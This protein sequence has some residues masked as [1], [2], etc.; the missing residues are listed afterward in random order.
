MNKY[1]KEG[2]RFVGKKIYKHNLVTQTWK[3]Q[4]FKYIYWYMSFCAIVKENKPKYQ[5]LERIWLMF[6]TKM[7]S[8][9]FVVRI[10]F[11]VCYSFFLEHRVIKICMH[12]GILVPLTSC[13]KWVLV[14][15]EKIWGEA[16]PLYLNNLEPQ[17]L[18]ITHF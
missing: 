12:W 1:E 9:K 6:K 15:L 5:L 14:I 8:R 4:I 7:L 13:Q 17:S 11:F 2:E 18:E 16:E 10:S 3:P